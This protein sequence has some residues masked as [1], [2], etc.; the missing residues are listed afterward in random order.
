MGSS[1]A[2]DKAYTLISIIAE[3]PKA[4]T[5][6]SETITANPWMLVAIGQRWVG[7][8]GLSRGVV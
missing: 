5:C 7:G 4:Q 1:D 2:E 8:S 6:K 3:K